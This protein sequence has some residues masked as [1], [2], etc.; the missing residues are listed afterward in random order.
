MPG[1]LH[2]LVVTPS[3]LS[4]FH[5]DFTLQSP[6]GVHVPSPR[7]K[8]PGDEHVLFSV[9][10]GLDEVSQGGMDISVAVEGMPP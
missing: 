1:P 8:A 9:T 10:F 4:G 2:T 7:R 6:L 5:G 3:C